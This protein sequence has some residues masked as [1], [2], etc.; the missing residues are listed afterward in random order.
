MRFKEFDKRSDEA[1]PALGKMAKGLG[2]VAGAVKQAGGVGAAVKQA[3]GVAGAAGAAKQVAGAAMGANKPTSNAAKQAQ[4]AQ[5]NLSKQLLKKGA[6]VPFP[7]QS[8]QAKEFEIDDVKG[9]EVTLVNPDAR[10]KPEEPEKL[11]YKKKDVDTVI[12]TLGQ[13]Q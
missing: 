4:K 12:K 13:Q 1:I 11:I 9:D 6:K 10:Q 3:G 2:A 5:A 8:G 7:T